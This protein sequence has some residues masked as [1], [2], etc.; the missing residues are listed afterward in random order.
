MSQAYTEAAVQDTD[1]DG[2]VRTNGNHAREHPILSSFPAWSPAWTHARQGEPTV[3]VIKEQDYAL[4]MVIELHKM[5][6]GLETKVMPLPGL[7]AKV[8]L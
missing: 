1:S 4:E 7:T 3:Q 5:E 6:W 8:M 2:E